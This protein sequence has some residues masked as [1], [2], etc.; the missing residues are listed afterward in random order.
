MLL[1]VVLG[2][3]PLNDDGFSCSLFTDQ[4]Y[5]LQ[6][7]T[8][9]YYWMDKTIIGWTR[10][11]LDGQDY[12]WMD[13]TIIGWTVHVVTTTYVNRLSNGVNK[14]GRMDIWVTLILQTQN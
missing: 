5:S 8:R 12:Y 10:L 7:E 13:K 1:N 9:L 6:E 14:V 3:V 11:L 2:H 4:Q